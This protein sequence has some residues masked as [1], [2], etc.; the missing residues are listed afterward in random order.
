MLQA[1]ARRNNAFTVRSKLPR[2]ATCIPRMVKSQDAE[3][4][5]DPAAACHGGLTELGLVGGRVVPNFSY[6]SLLFLHDERMVDDGR[7]WLLYPSRECESGGQGRATSV[8]EP[9]GL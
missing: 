2:I 5:E 3:A 6:G 8:V 9:G 7:T 1:L 4:G